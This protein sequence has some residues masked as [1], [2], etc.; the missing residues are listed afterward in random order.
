MSAFKFDHIHLYSREPM[1][2]AKWYEKMFGGKILQSVQTDGK[3][4]IDVEIG[5]ITL[6][7]LE[8]ARDAKMPDAPGVPHMGLEHF[9]FS[10]SNIDQVVAEMKGKGAKF[11][12]EPTTIRPGIRVAFV[13]APEKGRIELLER[14]EKFK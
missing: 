9:G 2:T 14:S 7:I 11:T 13:E 5:D 12:V 1:T 10:V 4:R 8:V 3:P 6:F